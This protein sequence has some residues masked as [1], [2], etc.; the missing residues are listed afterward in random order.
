[1]KLLIMPISFF[2]PPCSFYP[3]NSRYYPQR[4]QTP[5][6]LPLQREILIHFPFT[7]MRL[8]NKYCALERILSVR[9]DFYVWEQIF[10]AKWDAW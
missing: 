4:S 5:S 10:D 8:L 2:S 7:S 9:A 6:Y 3:P 1:M